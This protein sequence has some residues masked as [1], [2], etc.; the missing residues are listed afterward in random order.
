MSWLSDILGEGI[1]GAIGGLSLPQAASTALLL[2]AY[3]TEREALGDFLSQAQRGIT[4]IGTQTRQRLAFRPFT[5]TTS[6]GGDIATARTGDTT[7]TLSPEEQALQQQLLGGAGGLFGQAVGSTAGREADVYERIRAL[8]RPAEERQ[9]LATEERLAAQGRLGLQSAAFGGT[10]PELLAQ[11]QAIAQARD[12]ASLAAIQQAQA[13]QA[14][15]ASLGQGML[16][17]AYVPQASLLNVFQQGFQPAQLA[18]QMQQQAGLTGA[19]LGMAGLN[20]L[21][22]VQQARSGLTSGLLSSLAAQAA[23][24]AQNAPEGGTTL[25]DAIPDWLKSI[26]SI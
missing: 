12:A 21:L 26:L 8:Q 23:Q 4:D 13:E 16:A 3:G 25:G 15:A 2:G 18:A 22:G 20:T 9:R 7:F 19:E 10:S 5:V 1:T 17:S 14:Q 24:A 6:T 11:E